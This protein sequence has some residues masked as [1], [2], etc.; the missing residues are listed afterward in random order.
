[1]AAG[2]VGGSADGSIS[3]T[4]N[5]GVL[6]LRLLENGTSPDEPFRFRRFPASA[7]PNLAEDWRALG[8]RYG[9][10][11]PRR[12]FGGNL[13]GERTVEV[14]HWFPACGFA[15]ALCI[16]Y[17]RQRRR[18]QQV[19]SGVCPDCGYDLRATPQRC[20]ECGAEPRSPHNPPMQRTA[21]ASS[22]AVE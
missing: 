1:V 20:P 7:P 5:F 21:T 2:W 22:G 3:L 13:F 4:S 18:W 19:R 12:V 10:V 9:S 6:R 8:F 16:A 15:A 14:P 17:L 11:P